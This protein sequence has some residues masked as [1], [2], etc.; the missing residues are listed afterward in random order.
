MFVDPGAPFDPS[1]TGVPI[2]DFFVVGGPRCGTTTLSRCL[3]KNPQ[4]C[5]SKPKEPH[6]FSRLPREPSPDEIEALYLRRYFAHYRRSHRAVGEGSVSYLYAPGTLERILRLNPQAKFVAMVRDPLTMLPSYHLRMLFLTVED[7]PDFRTAWFLQDARTSGRKITRRCPDPRLLLY[8][9]V[10][11]FGGQIDRLYRLAGRERSKV[12]VFDDFMR[13]PL[14]S[15]REVLEF[16][17]VDDDGR[18]DVPTKLPSRTY[19]SRLLQSLIYRTAIHPQL[20]RMLLSPQNRMQ[21][22][23]NPI[24]RRKALLKRLARWNTVETKPPPLDEEMKTILREAF[25]ADVQRLS[26]LLGRN[27]AHWLG[28]RDGPADFNFV[29]R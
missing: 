8:R 17:G 15:Y 7:V 22:T 10:A 20:G 13:D 23:R 5:F 11:K 21:S 24:S 28:R 6:F 26:A 27:L 19:R 4:V 16:L 1:T 12:I 29:E 18:I 25:A 2:P 9:E 3:G 14:A